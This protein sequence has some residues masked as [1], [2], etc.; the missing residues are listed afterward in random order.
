MSQPLTTRQSLEQ[1][2]EDYG[3]QNE[4]PNPG[5]G[6]Q[7]LARASLK[8]EVRSTVSIRYNHTTAAALHPAGQ[9][10]HCASLSPLHVVS[11]C[12]CRLN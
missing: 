6:L 12:R 9:Q 10:T 11:F 8:D 4:G 2:I 5:L 7:Q 1:A 3:V